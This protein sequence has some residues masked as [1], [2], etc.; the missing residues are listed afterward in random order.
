MAPPS[1]PLLASATPSIRPPQQLMLFEEE[2]QA[3]NLFLALRPDELTAHV[4][5]ERA[6]AFRKQH[7]LRGRPLRPEH[8]HVSLHGIS[9]DMTVRHDLIRDVGEVATQ[10][11]AAPFE[12][13][14]DQ[15]M[16]L[17]NKKDALPFVLGETLVNLA[18][19][20]FHRE[21]GLALVRGGLGKKVSLQFTPHVT[22]L[23][24][25]RVVPR[26][27]VEPIRWTVKEFVLIDSLYGQTEHITRGVWPLQG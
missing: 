21:L 25:W 19:H 16:T 9:S 24:D 3:H 14:F 1:S 18:L 27:I 2:N 23:Y 8:F 7:N 12:A 22:L 13:I 17:I 6:N 10:F 11:R 26:Q 5:A 20:D 4:L 15:A